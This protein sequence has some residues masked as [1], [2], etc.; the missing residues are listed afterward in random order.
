MIRLALISC[1]LAAC[2]Q[3]NKVVCGDL[4]C[5]PSYTCDLANQRCLSPDQFSACIGLGDGDGC[6]VDGAPGTCGAGACLPFVCGDGVIT[7]AEECDGTNFDGKTCRDY[8]FYDDAG[9]TCSASCTVDIAGCTGFCGDG[10][11]NG[12]ELCDGAPP[13]LG[14]C[15]D[16]GYDAGPLG[17]SD[18]C[19]ASFATC[20]SI[21]W[22]V[23]PL[24]AVG[25]LTVAA[26]SPSNAWAVGN[27]GAIAHF[28]GLVWATETSPVTNDLVGVTAIGPGDAWAIGIDPTFGRPGVVMH[29]DAAGWQVV[30]GAPAAVYNDVWA[31]AHDHVYFA[32]RDQDVLEWNGTSF[33]PLGTLGA[34][35]TIVRGTSTSDVWAV[36]GDGSLWHWNGAS[37]TQA[38][39]TGTV[40]SLVAVA[41]DDVW[42]VGY[43]S[44]FAGMIAHWDGSTWSAAFDPSLQ[45]S[46]I[47]ASGPKDAWVILPT[48]DS[49]HFDGTS[50]SYVSITF[51]GAG[52]TVVALGPGDAIGVTSSGFAYHYS[53]QAFA[54][55]SLPTFGPGVGGIYSS[56]GADLY[57]ALGTGIYH[58]GYT[59]QLAKVYT[60]PYNGSFTALGGSSASNIWALSL[61]GHVYH[62]DTTWTE[63]TAP[64][65]SLDGVIWV[66]PSDVWTFSP[67]VAHHGPAPWTDYTSFP[68]STFF[69]VSGST[70]SDVWAIQQPLSV[71]SM[72]AKLWHWNGASWTEVVP[73]RTDLSAVGARAPNDVFVATRSDH[74]LHWD[75]TTW[76]DVTVPTLHALRWI[77]PMAADDVF[78]AS[79]YDIVHFDGTRWSRVRPD[80]DP[81]ANGNEI[82]AVTSSG[83]GHLQFVHAQNNVRDLIRTQPWVCRASETNCNDGMD[84]DCD[85]KIDQLDSDCP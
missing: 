72:G 80:L 19:G 74:V 9:L 24:G 48:G 69:S 59:Y 22:K 2:V 42:A 77:E 38:A 35:V 44:A 3:S 52:V 73:P 66:G 51:D 78:A 15:Y 10:M 20:A 58:P 84:D 82:S 16:F 71:T 68:P 25:L 23:A 47:A 26:S 55:Y 60:E 81:T 29:R 31:V 27:Q 28:N 32:T 33:Q 7:G 30:T 40:T 65:G 54:H 79:D 13:P 37:W 50:W 18:T 83:P 70:A 14:A 39:L 56:S 1:A 67:G 34:P 8:H 41:S 17:C 57:V 61:G 11:I 53:G 4:T 43:G 76:T 12:S 64:G 62:F 21:G 85:G 63:Q 75:G 46:S 45:Y 36:E 6:T 5:P 49:L